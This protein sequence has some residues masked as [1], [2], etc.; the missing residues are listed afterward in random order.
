MKPVVHQGL[1]KNISQSQMK[2]QLVAAG[3]VDGGP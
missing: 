3:A 1:L 2:G